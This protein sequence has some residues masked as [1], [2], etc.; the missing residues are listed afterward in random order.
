MK[1]KF[2]RS[3]II[4]GTATV[5]GSFLAALF[6]SSILQ[7]I[8]YNANIRFIVLLLNS[9]ES[10][11]AMFVAVKFCS[12]FIFKKQLNTS[13]F[14]LMSIVAGIARALLLFIVPIRTSLLNYVLS[15][16]IF[17]LFALFF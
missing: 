10:I 16:A 7:A 9:I 6:N 2:G 14:L 12:S 17:Y 15:F 8:G 5:L 11:A 3:A 13:E 4:A 1:N